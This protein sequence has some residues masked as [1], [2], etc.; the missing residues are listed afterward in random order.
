MYS[1]TS[2]KSHIYS[3]IWMLDQIDCTCEPRVKPLTFQYLDDPHYLDI[4][5]KMLKQEKQH[6]LQNSIDV[7]CIVM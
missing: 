4:L 1:M 5:D 3:V 6:E 2:Q 7:Y